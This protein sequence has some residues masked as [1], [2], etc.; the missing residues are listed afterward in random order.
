MSHYTVF[1]YAPNHLIYYILIP[2]R[3]LSPTIK[4]VDL[5]MNPQKKY[6]IIKDVIQNDNKLRASLKLGCT[7]LHINR[8]IQKYRQIGKAAFIHGYSGRQTL[9]L[10]PIHKNHL[11][12]PFITINTQLLTHSLLRT[13]KKT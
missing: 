12:S 6:E 3:K 11:L 13:S 7:V 9:I 4:K 5:N 8:L 2:N 10:S 1:D